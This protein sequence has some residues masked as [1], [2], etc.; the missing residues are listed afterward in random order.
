ME[1]IWQQRVEQAVHKSINS[2]IFSGFNTNVDAV[3][4]CKGD[5]IARLLEDPEISLDVVNNLDPDQIDTIKDKNDFVATLKDCLGNGKS[6]HIVLEDINLLDW[7]DEMFPE[8][9]EIMGGQA[10]II[11][12]QMAKLAKKSVVYTSL[13]S[14]KQAAM[15]FPEVLYPVHKDSLELVPVLDAYRKE[16]RL[17]I[18]WI[19]EYAKG[20]EL[21][22]GGEKVV[23]PRA[24]RVILATRPPGVVMGFTGDTLEHLPELGKEID[25]AFMAGYHYAPSEQEALDEYLAGVVESIQL[26][27]S[28]NEDIQFHYEYVPMKDEA[29]EKQVLTTVADHF[30]SF[31]INENEIRRVLKGF[32]FSKELAE[33][34]NNERA[35]SLYKG[36]LRLMEQLNFSRIHLHNLGYYILL[37]RKPYIVKPETVRE[38]CLFAS[39]VNA[40][41]AKYGGYVEKSR[42]VEATSL[43]LSEIG[44]KQL[45]LF[46]Q[47]A[48]EMGL[49][50]P[51]DFSQTGIWERDQHYLVLVPAHV[52]PNPVSTVGMGDTISSSSFASEHTEVLAS[53]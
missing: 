46:E 29:A 10:G 22:F 42:V 5:T 41:K 39:A 8:R 6:F 21:N 37:L 25:V 47:E 52:Y 2:S 11:A 9:Q 45:R 27:K 43:P 51:A 23:T 50:I 34:E 20:I 31:G 35:F 12:N 16:D 4:H 3:V 13:L 38:C 28:G 18:N 32:G 24:N 44:L 1:S 17:K 15:F 40:M 33:I 36:A 53:R 49:D 26:L 19:F 7:L 30:Q 48:R 14:K